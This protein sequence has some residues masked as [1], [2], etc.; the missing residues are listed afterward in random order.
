MLK[1]FGEF[2]LAKE[3]N[4]IIIAFLA[5][6]LPVFSLPTGFIAVLVVG[7]I[8]LQK[9]PK[10]GLWILSWV[11]LPAIALLVTRHVG[12]FDLLF[13]RCVVIWILASLLRR[14]QSWSLLFEIVAVLGVIAVA[15]LHWW[16]PQLGQWWM[17]QLTDYMQ[18]MVVDAKVK[19]AATATAELA[20]R[21]A[22]IATGVIAFFVSMTVLMELAVVRWWQTAL[23]DP[24]KF[25]QEAVAV[26][27]GK[28]ASLLAILFFVLTMMKL[29]VAIDA[30]AIVLLPLFLAGL[31]LLHYLARRNKRFMYLL[32]VI[33]AGFIFL[34]VLVVSALAVV[35]FVDSW[36]DFRKRLGVVV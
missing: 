9:G 17:T 8:T 26:R 35:A 27:A 32:I 12:L 15:A 13:V 6:L 21:V 31:S 2:L 11:A 30:F 23:F 16:N 28:V 24:G 36:V 20:K 33:Y 7:L 29:P 18:K 22:P 19:D 14:Y 5:A 34:P 25:A 3:A 4:A 10:A 1:K